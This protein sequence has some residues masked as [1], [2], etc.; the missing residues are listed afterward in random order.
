MSRC[1]ARAVPS[2]QAVGGSCHEA[3]AALHQDGDQH[4]ASHRR[5]GSA[6]AAT[7]VPQPC[8]PSPTDCPLSRQQHLSRVRQPSRLGFIPPVKWSRL[9]HSIAV[10]STHQL[11]ARFR[12][13]GA[14]I[15][16]VPAAVFATLAIAPGH[17]RLCVRRAA[18]LATCAVVRLVMHAACQAAGTTISGHF[19]IAHQSG[20]ELTVIP[21]AQGWRAA[22]V[23]LRPPGGVKL[24]AQARQSGHQELPVPAGVEDAACYRDEQ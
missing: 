11:F 24:A 2:V 10:I 13:R 14:S 8:P 18:R 20:S 4:D 3:Q 21:K 19:P 23:R 16:C 12:H 5:G 9:K 22:A 1:R 6:L 17:D 15:P 7:A